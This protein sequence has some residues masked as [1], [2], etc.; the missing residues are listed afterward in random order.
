MFGTFKSQKDEL[1]FDS[2]ISGQENEKI[3]QT[4]KPKGSSLKPVT[5][6]FKFL[7]KA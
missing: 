3:G 5:N 1:E 4:H 7:F 2:I 6:G